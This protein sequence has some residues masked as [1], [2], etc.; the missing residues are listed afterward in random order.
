MSIIYFYK[1]IN[2]IFCVF[3]VCDITT[4]ASIVALIDARPTDGICD[5][6]C[7]LCN[8]LQVTIKLNNKYL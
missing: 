7:L 8:N 3:V 4:E 6:T 2:N 1:N 5:T